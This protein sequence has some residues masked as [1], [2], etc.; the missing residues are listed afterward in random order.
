VI[1]VE[2]LEV[3]AA[4]AVA[5]PVIVR[6][7]LAD[8]VDRHSIGQG[9]HPQALGDAFWIDLVF[10]AV[11]EDGEPVAITT[12]V[13]RVARQ[14]GFRRRSDYDRKRVEL[15]RL[16]GRLIHTGRL[17]R[18]A[19]KYVAIPQNDAR[20]QALLAAASAPVDLPTPQV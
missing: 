16:I 11:R 7:P 14:G 2:P 15:F 1:L 17:D 9:G 20:R 8:L 19:R 10:E 5:P 13:N 3:H 4:R 18:V 12:V 6:A